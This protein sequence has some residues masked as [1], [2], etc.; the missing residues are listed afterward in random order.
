MSDV[1]ISYS[2]KDAEQALQLSE[3][4]ASAGLSVWLDNQSLTPATS[5][6][7]EIVQ[8]INECRVMIVLLSAA[9]TQ[10]HNVIKEVSLASEKRK[11]ILPLELEPI[12]LP[13]D[14]EYQLAGIQRSSMSNID[15]ILRALGKLG[16]EA[17]GAPVAPVIAKEIDS[18]KSLM[19]LPFEDLSP[20]RD[21]E[22]FA[23]GIASEL[24]AAFSS[25]K[26]LRLIDWNTSKM[27]KERRIRT[28]DLAHEL[29]VRYFLEGSVRKFGDQLKITA[30]LLDINEGEY[31]WQFSE[32][33]TMQEI[34]ELQEAVA[35]KVV[36]GLK[37][38]LTKEEKSRLEDRGTENVEAYGL[39]MKAKQYAD[40]HTRDDF[41]RSISLYKAAITLDPRYTNVYVS[42]AAT[43][44]ALYQVYDRNLDHLEVAESMSFRAKELNPDLPELY[45][46]MSLIQRLRGNLKAAEEYEI[47]HVRRAPDNSGSHFALGSFYSHTGSF[48]RAI[49]CYERALE[50]RPDSLLAYWNL[51]VACDRSGEHA[52]IRDVAERAIPHLEKHLR[53][54]PD[55]EMKQVYYANALYY[56]GKQEQARSHLQT[57]DWIKD[58]GSL[59]N[60]ACLAITLGNHSNAIQ[61]LERSLAPGFA[62]DLIRE[63]P[64]LDPLREMPEFIELVKR[65]EEKAKK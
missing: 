7:R 31:L 41:M 54:N 51:L 62:I 3:L 26:S 53:L 15:A 13:E 43:L 1:F 22:W 27:V 34:F 11:K 33:G 9:S 47:E 16:L 12:T 35:E 17:T 58:S 37:L 32:K 44:A 49:S 28:I 14:L 19:I 39:Y 64:D 20:T 4:L 40:R 60:L 30:T 65:W 10:S 63:D 45:N 29:N 52:K 48:D 24:I 23:D 42:A 61:L 6:S 46:A 21:N 5:W 36:K 56:A 2:R 38:H 18:R 57:L 25:V 8:A 50:I 55:D 59:Y